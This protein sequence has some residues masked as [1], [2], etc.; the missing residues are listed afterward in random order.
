M[1]WSSLDRGVEPAEVVRLM[2]GEI[3]QNTNETND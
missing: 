3:V 1:N 2:D